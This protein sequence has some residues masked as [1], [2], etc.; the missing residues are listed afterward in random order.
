MTIR[1]MVVWDL[2]H[3]LLHP[4]ILQYVRMHAMV[5]IVVVVTKGSP[6]FTATAALVPIRVDTQMVILKFMSILVEVKNLAD[7]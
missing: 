6:L 4:A 3:A 2:T 5:L 1:A 7:L